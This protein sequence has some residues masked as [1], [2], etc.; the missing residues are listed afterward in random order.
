MTYLV[1]NTVFELDD[2]GITSRAVDVYEGSTN[3]NLNDPFIK[4]GRIM[5]YLK[6]DTWFVHG[7]PS[8]DINLDKKEGLV[9]VTN[10]HILKRLWEINKNDRPD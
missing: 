2:E 8:S 3:Y 1:L 7:I 6:C 10:P 5:Y 9:E 4:V